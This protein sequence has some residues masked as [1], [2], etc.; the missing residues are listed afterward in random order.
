MTIYDDV[1][2]P[3]RLF[4]SCTPRYESLHVPTCKVGTFL[5]M[6]VILARCPS[7][8]HQWLTRLTA[9]LEPIFA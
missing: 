8:G 5:C 1:L 2:V 4:N 7:W 6:A 3:M 9:Q